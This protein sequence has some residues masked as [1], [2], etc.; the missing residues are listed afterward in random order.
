MS[1]NICKTLATNINDDYNYALTTQCTVKRSLSG[2]CGSENNNVCELQLLYR[3]SRTI[4]DAVRPFVRSLIPQRRVRYSLRD[5]PRN[6]L[7]AFSRS[8][9][10]HPSLHFDVKQQPAATETTAIRRHCVH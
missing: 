6:A 9:L 4:S 1:N 7:A 2:C 5:L 10:V 3:S 8:S